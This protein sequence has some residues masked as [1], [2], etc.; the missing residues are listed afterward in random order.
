[1]QRV[2]RDS[3]KGIEMPNE[4]A[5]LKG[6]LKA[7]DIDFSKAIRIEA[8]DQ[9]G[10]CQCVTCG[11]RAF[12]NDRMQAGHFIGKPDSIRYVELGVHVQCWICN[13]TGKSHSIDYTRQ[14]TEEVAH[15]YMRFMLDRY[16]QRAI[17]ALRRLKN[18]S[19]TLRPEEMRVMRAWYKWRFQV[20]IKEKGL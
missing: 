7:T 18:E 2:Q 13:T 9:N 20:A 10:V 14:K 17:D 16:G 5:D 6:W 8:S 1:M 19:K 15:A 12:W 4:P 11:K 3:R